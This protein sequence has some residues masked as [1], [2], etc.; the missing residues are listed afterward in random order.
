VS[1]SRDR[2]NAGEP[3]T[4]SGRYEF[5]ADG[6]WHSVP[7]HY[8]AIRLCL[9]PE[10]DRGSYDYVNTD[11]NGEFTT[12]LLPNQTGYYRVGTYNEDPFITTVTFARFDMVVLQK[13]ELTSFGAQ[14]D[15]EGKVAIAGH[16]LFGHFTPSPAPVE[17]QFSATGGGDW[18]TLATV[19][20]TRGPS[21]TGGYLFRATIDEPRP[22]YWRAV[23]RGVPDNFQSDVSDSVFV[24]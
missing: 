7:N 14:R 13:A 23:Y 10:C 16:L 5:K 20:A 22:G 1:V 12:T 15:T 8:V 11:A 2:I 17:I 21:E 6:A 3:V 9:D 4:I 18:T 19:D 24:G